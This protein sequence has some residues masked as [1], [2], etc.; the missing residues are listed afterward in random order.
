MD[1]HTT[2]KSRSC[3]ELALY[4]EG[5]DP[6]SITST[7]GIVPTRTWRKGD[8]IRNGPLVRKECCWELAS[9]YQVCEDAGSLASGI[10]KMFEG[11]GDALLSAVKELGLSM[12]MDLV[13]YTEQ[14]RAPSLRLSP[15]CV[16]F[17][18]RY[19]GSI[20][21]D[22]YFSQFPPLPGI[23]GEPLMP[24]G[25]ASASCMGQLCSE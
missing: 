22:L 5:F 8:P 4:G 2:D 9:G 24:D 15:E 23:V 11:K 10:V 13:I 19:G 18:D 20:A 14:G 16:R 12:R 7:L 21:T 1:A 17:V 3:A 25:Q 6:D